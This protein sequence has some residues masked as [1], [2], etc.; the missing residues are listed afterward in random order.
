MDGNRRWARERGLPTL[1]GHRK[2]YEKLKEVSDW[3]KEAGIPNL[4]V[5]GFSTENW[6]R[7]Q[8]EVSYLMDLIREMLLRDAEEMRQRSG[9]MKIVGQRDRFAPDIQK[10]MLDA[11]EMTKEGTHTLW[12]ALSYGGRAEITHAVNKLLKEGKK[13]VSEEE[14][15]KRLWTSGMPDPDLII[16][17]S[18]EQ[19]L[20]GFLPWQGV[21]S[22][23]FFVNTHWP[24][25]SKEDFNTVLAQYAERERRMGK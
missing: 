15:S 7:A 1:E 13:E 14:V 6:S 20:S 9:R 5:Y 21:Y 8:E 17:T 19:R 4:V 11:E 2:G 12:L 10:A 23:L 18:G 22:E 16:R 25:F 24:A 3:C